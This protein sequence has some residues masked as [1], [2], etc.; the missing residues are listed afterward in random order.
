MAAVWSEGKGGEISKAA[1]H[2][3]DF[4]NTG[5]ETGITAAVTTM[6]KKLPY[7]AIGSIGSILPLSK[8][9][10]YSAL[11]ARLTETFL[12]SRFLFKVFKN[13]LHAS[14]CIAIK[15]AKFLWLETDVL[16]LRWL[17][18]FS[19]TRFHLCLSSVVFSLFCLRTPRYKFSSTLYPPKLLVYNASY[20]QSIIYI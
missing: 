7:M 12:K 9:H 15:S 20:T 8:R 3:D 17:R 14:A 10:W 19:R 11:Y 16:P 5:Y 6:F 13:K 1:I 2:L 18:P 4:G